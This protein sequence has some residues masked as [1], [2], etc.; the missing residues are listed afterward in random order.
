M[1]CAS[2]ADEAIRRIDEIVRPRLAG[3]E[4]PIQPLGIFVLAGP[5]EREAI[6]VVMGLARALYGD[7]RAFLRLDMAEYTEKHQIGLL[8]GPPPG[9]VGYGPPGHLPEPIRLRPEQVVLLERIERV[10]ADAQKI[11]LHIAERA[12]FIDNFGR[13]VGFRKTLMILT[14]EAGV[15]PREVIRPELFVLTRRRDRLRKH[16]WRRSRIDFTR[17]F[18][19]GQAWHEPPAESPAIVRGFVPI[20]P[21]ARRTRGRPDPAHARSTPSPR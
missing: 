18:A 21:A 10:H 7:V 15:V 17:P 9:I 3:P 13:E 12:P 16:G 6:W 20:A 11:L 2:T 19:G 14:I 1:D 4:R 5:T 8:V